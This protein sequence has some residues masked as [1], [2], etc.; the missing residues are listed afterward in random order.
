MAFDNPAFG[1]KNYEEYLRAGK[2]TLAVEYLTAGD[3][4]IIERG[5]Y[6]LEVAHDRLRKRKDP[7]ALRDAYILMTGS[8]YLGSRCLVSESEREYWRRKSCGAGGG[9]EDAPQQQ[10]KVW[11]EYVRECL[12]N[13]PGISIAILVDSLL[14]DTKAPKCLPNSREYLLKR[15]RK[16]KM[17]AAGKR[18][19]LRLVQGGKT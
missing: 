13:N 6:Y 5:I 12:A 18:D 15:V 19:V 3:R 4:S 1:R 16:I 10:R 14:L 17:E 2:E 9:K 7:E 8:Y 11:E